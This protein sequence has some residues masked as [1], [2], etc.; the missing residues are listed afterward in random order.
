MHEN[1]SKCHIWGNLKEKEFI[2]Q[3]RDL[4]T[5]DSDRKILIRGYFNQNK[6]TA[7]LK[8]LNKSD[9]MNRGKFVVSSIGDVPRLFKGSFSNGKFPKVNQSETFDVAGL[10][11]KF[12]KRNKIKDH[13]YSY[14]EDFVSFFPVES[15][16]FI[17]K[18]TNIFI[19]QLQNQTTP[20][21]IVITTNDYSRK[22]EKLYPYVSDVLILDT[23]DEHKET[24]DTLKR[25]IESEGKEMPY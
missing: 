17:E 5:D 19:S 25:N 12:E 11:L 3:L 15:L 7:V 21:V 6:L 22:A 16:L 9:K 24:Y 14:K 8:S 13:N 1:Q 23:N 18:D 4:L 2:D 10:R 20:K